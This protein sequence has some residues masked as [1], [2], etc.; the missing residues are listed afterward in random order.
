M[1][2]KLITTTYHP[3]T[4]YYARIFNKQE[5]YR[6]T[7]SIRNGDFIF[8][9][10]VYLHWKDDQ[11][12]DIAFDISSM[13][14]CSYECKFCAAADYFKGILTCDEIVEQVL[15]STELIQK[16]QSDFFEKCKLLTFSF[17]GMGEPSLP[18]VSN[19]ILSAIEKLKI[20]FKDKR[21]NIQFIISTIGAHPEVIKEWG[22]KEIP[23]ETLQVSIHGVS[24]NIR[25][26]LLGKNQPNLSEI[27]NALLNFSKSNPSVLIKIN[28]L[29]M[30]VNEKSNVTESELK[31][32]ITLL[33]GTG[34]FIKLAHLNLT[35]ASK[36]NNIGPISEFEAKECYSF[37][38]NN[39]EKAYIY[40]TESKL[41]ISCGQLAS[42]AEKNIQ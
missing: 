25:R 31:S 37:M 8:E 12:V 27:F 1:P 41:G 23:L 32:L 17:E 13:S 18:K 4:I 20:H 34:F 21:Q 42:Y 28:Y 35:D 22:K 26:S 14:G 30:K 33:S 36:L 9:T 38:K 24:D 29:M 3:K 7:F 2:I 40:G 15:F 5:G 16:K 39:Y 19:Q 6:F 11:I 10:G